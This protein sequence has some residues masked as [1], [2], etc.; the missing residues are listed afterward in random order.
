MKA[1]NICD[2]LDEDKVTET[3]YLYE[4]GNIISICAFSAR[5]EGEEEEMKM[6]ETEP[7]MIVR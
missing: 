2:K 4:E 7:E 1:I 3:I 5:K 6:E